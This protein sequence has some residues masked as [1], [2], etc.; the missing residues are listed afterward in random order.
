MNSLIQELVA[1]RPVLADGAWGTELLSQGLEPGECSD[2]WNLEH[3]GRVE[4]LARAYVEAGSRVILTN[5]FR[6]N[7]IALAAFGLAGKVREINRAGVE[8]SRR[9]AGGRARVFASL[10][11]SGKLLVAGEVSKDELREAFLE[12]A[13]MLTDA[14]AEGLV[15]ETMSDLEEAKLAVEAARTTGLP[16]V[17]CMAFDSGKAKDRTMMGTTPEQAAAG[18]SAAGA[19]VIGANC[20][21]GIGH[22][23][24]LCRRLAAATDRP[25]WMK[26]N[27][28]VPELRGDRVRYFTTPEKFAAAASALVREGATFIGGCCGTGPDFIRALGLALGR[29]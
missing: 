10:G 2:A 23:P 28:G 21:Q 19:D 26:P 11:P 27:A 15:I 9:A 7:R 1:E 12:Q 14:G 16:V 17:A 24:G 20:G 5:T 8:I 29:S 13:E 3:S 6:S 25:L 22:Y 18:L 4:Y